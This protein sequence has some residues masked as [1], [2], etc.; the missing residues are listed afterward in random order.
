M[1]GAGLLPAV[2]RAQPKPGAPKIGFVLSAPRQ[3]A[4]VLVET[5]MGGVRDS[6]RSAP[7]VEAVVRLGGGD[8][9][10]LTALT[11]EVL[12]M[13]VSV[14]LGD[15]PKHLGIAQAAT[16]TVPIVAIDFEDDP[17]AAGYARSIARPGGNVTGIFLDLPDF[18]GKW[19]EFLRECMPQLSSIALMWDASTG[20]TQLGALT[21]TAS[22]LNMRTELFEVKDRDDYAGAFALAKSHGVEAAILLSTPLI[23]SIIKDLAELALRHKLPTITMFSDFARAG[24]LLSYGPNLFGAMRQVGVLMG[25]VLS[26]AAPADLPIE[27]PTKFEFLIN[28]R[29][30]QAF[31]LTIPPAIL[32]RA[33]EVIE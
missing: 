3:F 21:K 19:I 2:G 1:A 12:A 27:R 33:D 5:M 13:N 8:R 23:P 29:T 25:K 30:A 32:V 15:G 17:V 7:Q 31:G 24:G 16:R 22:A 10:R 4:D 9:A 20:P 6:S 14:L 26:G 11:A 18:T 28:L